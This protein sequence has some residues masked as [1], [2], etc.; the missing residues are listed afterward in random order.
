VPL[1]PRSD[2]NWKRLGLT[3]GLL[4]SFLL[5]ADSALF[6]QNRTLKKRIQTLS[7]SLLP[8]VGF[9]MPPLV[10]VGE[11]GASVSLTYSKPARKTLLFVFSPVCEVCLQNW[12]NWLTI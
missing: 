6:I 10:G 1:R 2:A 8:P 12:N 4:A 7:I 9:A 11:G 5:A 3:F